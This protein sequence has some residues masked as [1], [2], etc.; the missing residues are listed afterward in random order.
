MYEVVIVYKD[1]EEIDSIWNNKD[2]ANYRLRNW[3]SEWSGSETA[4]GHV[5]ERWEVF[6]V[7]EVDVDGDW[8]IDSLWSSRQDASNR[9]AQIRENPRYC[10]S[11][12]EAMTVNRIV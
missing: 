12:C 7:K 10:Y 5:R 3:A 11:Y 6:V 2:S 4:F 8:G 9:L 1:R